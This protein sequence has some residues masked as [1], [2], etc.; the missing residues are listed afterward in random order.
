[1][2]RPRKYHADY[3]PHPNN[4]RLDRKVRVIRTQFGHEG[5]AAIVMLFEL[6]AGSPYFRVRYT[7]MELQ[8]IA[9]EFE[10]DPETLRQIIDT[11]IGIELLEVEQGYLFSPTLNEWLHP[12]E[13]YR[14]QNRKRKEKHDRKQDKVV[15]TRENGLFTRENEVVT[16][17]NHSKNMENGVFRDE[18]AA[19]TVEYS[20]ANTRSIGKEKVEKKTAS[21]K[22]THPSAEIVMPFESE[23]FN[24]VWS[25]WKKYKAEQ[26]K[27]RYKGSISEQA[28]LKNLAELAHQDENSAIQIINNSI[29]NGYQGLF[30][31]KTSTS[32]ANKHASGQNISDYDILNAVQQANATPDE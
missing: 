8:L 6:L 14:N 24:A 4:L 11:A 21:K 1:M 17:E 27:F 30:K 29:A 13:N 9:G 2:G 5:Y 20:K 32:A 18:S 26:F 16:G 28:A 10:V 3:F 22:M 31:P 7:E 12:L 25:L 15:L 19:S 23:N